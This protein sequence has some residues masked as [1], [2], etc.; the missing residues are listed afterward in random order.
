MQNR[1][2]TRL[3]FAK[4]FALEWGRAGSNDESRTRTSTIEGLE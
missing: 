3:I 1:P 2:A 4:A